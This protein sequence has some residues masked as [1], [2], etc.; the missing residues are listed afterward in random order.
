MLGQIQEWF[1]HDLAGIRSDGNGFKKITIAPQP[2]GDV[3]WAKAGYNSV[4]GKIISDWKR[5]GGRFTLKVTIPP[6]TTATV[7]V[8]TKSGG[9]TTATSGARFLRMDFGCD[10][11]EAG[12]GDYKFESSF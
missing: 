12:S 11:F 3:T 6:N 7:L 5:D 10:V 9:T 4:R 2:V 8:P 1:Y